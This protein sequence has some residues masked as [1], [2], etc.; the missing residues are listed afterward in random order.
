VL[1]LENLDIMTKKKMEMMVQ[2]KLQKL[3]RNTF[4]DAFGTQTVRRASTTIV[5]K[6]F[7][8]K[9]NAWIVN[10]KEIEP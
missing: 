4:N 10:A 1:L 6:F 2:K 9:L 7:F 8:Q 5:A 3:R